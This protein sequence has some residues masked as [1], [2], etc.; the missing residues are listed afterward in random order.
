MLLGAILLAVGL[1]LMGTLDETTNVVELGVFMA[2]VGAGIGMLGIVAPIA[3]LFL[4]EVPLGSRSEIEMAK[5]AAPQ[6][7]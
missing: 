1:A 2:L 3:L 4:R 7:A 5:E 6:G